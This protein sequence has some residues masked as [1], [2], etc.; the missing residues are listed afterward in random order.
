MSDWTD[1][2]RRVERAQQFFE[3]RKWSDALREIRAATDINPYNPGWFFNMG[4]ILDEMG[5]F[6]E[7]LEAY[8]QARNIEPRD[9]QTLNHVGMDLFRLG[10]FDKAI[11]T[12]EEIEKIDASFEPSYCNRII[13]Y[14]QQGRHD[15]AEEM[16]YTARLYKEHCP[17]CYYNMGVSLEARG[18]Y[19]KAIF[20]WMRSLDLQG[21]QNDVHVRIAHAHWMKGDREE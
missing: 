20:C 21:G 8:G 4:L 13:A 3:Q 10:M 11:A 2:E 19:D 18:L 7:A 6:E 9:L 17:H 16:F 1:A 15:L 14:A 5:R 12:C